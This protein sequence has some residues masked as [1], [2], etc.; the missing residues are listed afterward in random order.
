MEATAPSADQALAP[1]APADRLRPLPA[2]LV[3]MFAT[4]DAFDVDAFLTFLSPDCE[5]RFGNAPSI[6]GHEPIRGM[7]EGFFA[8]IKGMRHNE[9]E[10]WVHPDATMCTG[11]VTYV[12]H[13][14]TELTVPF[15]VVFRLDHG[16]VRQYLIFVDNSQLFA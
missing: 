10:A 13:N 15:A 2:W 9:L 6:Y 8:A 7:L 16:L 3:E 11:K 5:F 14:G 1:S 4:I 12:R